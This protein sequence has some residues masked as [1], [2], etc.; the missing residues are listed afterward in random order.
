MLKQALMHFSQIAADPLD[1]LWSVTSCDALLNRSANEIE[2][3]L[4]RYAE[5]MHGIGTAAAEQQTGW[6]AI[7][8]RQ[9][10]GKSASLSA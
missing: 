7:R 8:Q 6:F 4:D 2:P 5:L 1:E 9:G 3:L 10:Q